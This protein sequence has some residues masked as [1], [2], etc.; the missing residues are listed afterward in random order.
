MADHNSGN[1]EHSIDELR[2]KRDLPFLTEGR[3]MATKQIQFSK[4]W[5]VLSLYLP[6]VLFCF[7]STL[8]HHVK[9]AYKRT[10]QPKYDRKMLFATQ[11]L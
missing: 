5:V 4:P 11:T 7:A 9:E 3:Q 8:S 6:A 10:R 1:M 2:E